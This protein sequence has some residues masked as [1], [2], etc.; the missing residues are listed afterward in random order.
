M[1]QRSFV[2]ITGLRS[3]V[4]M[5]MITLTLRSNASRIV[6]AYPNLSPLVFTDPFDGLI[7]FKD[8]CHNI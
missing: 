7:H 3:E 4:L 2:Q 8:P 1:R 5:A 6:F